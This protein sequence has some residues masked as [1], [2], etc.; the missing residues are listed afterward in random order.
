[1]HVLVI[2]INKLVLKIYNK[3]IHYAKK[4]KKKNKKRKKRKNHYTNDYKVFSFTL[5]DWPLI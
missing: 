1:M 5:L 4:I 2:Q 3:I